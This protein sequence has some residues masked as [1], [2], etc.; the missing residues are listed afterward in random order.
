MYTWICHWYETQ[1][2]F[3][4]HIFEYICVKAHCAHIMLRVFLFVP[5]YLLY[6][7]RLVGWNITS[8]SPYIQAIIE[9][10][11]NVFTPRLRF[12]LLYSFKINWLEWKKKYINFLNR[13]PPTSASGVEMHSTYIQILV[14]EPISVTN[15][16]LPQQDIVTPS[17]LK[18][19]YTTQVMVH[20]KSNMHMLSI[21][22]Q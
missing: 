2:I 13:L 8:Q 5:N 10:R 1:G 12:K 22:L 15:E 14:H 19:S 16:L 17:G 4:Y 20:G 21:M 18:L 3:C 7:H 9:F 11:G 6:F